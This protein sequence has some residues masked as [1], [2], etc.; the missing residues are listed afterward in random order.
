MA[1][2]RGQYGQSPSQPAS[3]KGNWIAGAVIVGAGALFLRAAVK[4]QQE[5]AA[6]HKGYMT[7]H[8]GLRAGMT[9]S[10]KDAYWDA[11]YAKRG[12]MITKAGDLVPLEKH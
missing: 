7:Q 1:N 3:S 2:E 5:N 8:P 12:L 6:A 4:M 9:S 11:H 10:E